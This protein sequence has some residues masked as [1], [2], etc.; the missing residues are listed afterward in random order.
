MTGLLSPEQL[1]DEL[2]VKVEQVKTW[3]R[4]HDWPCVRFS[5]KTV[6]YTPEQVQQIVAMHTEVTGEPDPVDDSKVA[7]LRA[8]QTARSRRHRAS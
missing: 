3:T 2:G 5:L 8:A 1:A 7:Q 6:R 4:E